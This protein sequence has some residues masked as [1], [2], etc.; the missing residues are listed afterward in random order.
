MELNEERREY[1]SRLADRIMREMIDSGYN[2]FK[3]VNYIA[4][5]D[6]YA[7]NLQS[8]LNEVVENEKLEPLEIFYLGLHIGHHGY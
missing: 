7:K 4:L 5:N 8:L 6:T 2:A 1:L 3:A